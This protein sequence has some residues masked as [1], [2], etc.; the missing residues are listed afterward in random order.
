MKSRPWIMGWRVS[1]RTHD[2][3]GVAD[4]ARRRNSALL[5]DRA[6]SDVAL[7]SASVLVAGRAAQLLLG[8]AQVRLLFG[9]LSREDAGLFSYVTS[10]A[11]LLATLADMGATTI[12]AREA[13]RA[14]EREPALLGALTTAKLVLAALAVVAFLGVTAAT[15]GHETS[16]AVLA[17]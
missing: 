3:P 17:T 11:A 14:P 7:R 10:L 6:M 1:Y 2:A 16:A 12:A 4:A 8:V 5:D 15:V 13:S 9:T